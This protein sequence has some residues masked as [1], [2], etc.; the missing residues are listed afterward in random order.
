MKYLLFLLVAL[1]TSQFTMGLKSDKINGERILK[2][3][4]DDDDH[5]GKGKVS[6]ER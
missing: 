4:G 6:L 2:S 5:S 1:A 3:K